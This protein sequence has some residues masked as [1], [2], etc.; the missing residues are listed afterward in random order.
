MGLLP[1]R[2]QVAQTDPCGQN[3]VPAWV[4]SGPRCP[5]VLGW[6]GDTPPPRLPPQSL[7]T[8]VR[9][10]AGRDPRALL[11]PLPAHT[12]ASF[13]G[14]APAACVTAVLCLFQDSPIPNLTL[15]QDTGRMAWTTG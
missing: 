7:G 9:T 10:E 15:S 3:T 5:G 4:G 14:A 11:C 13:R 2:L 1:L 6:L 12:L 8:E